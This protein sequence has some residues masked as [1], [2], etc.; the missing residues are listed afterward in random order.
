MEQWTKVIWTD[1]SKFEILGS[2]RKVYVWWKVGES[3]NPLYY[4]NHK[5]RRRLCY[6]LGG[7]SPIAKSEICTRW[8][9]NWIRL[10]ITAYCSIMQSHLE[11]GWWVK[12]FY[13]C[14]IMTQ[15]IRVN[16]TRG[17][18]KAKRNSTSFNS[19]INRLKSHRP[20]VG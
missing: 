2:N 1:E 7:R 5:A 14:K 20:V 19:T 10:A 6:G 17:T 3:C 9:E 13:S 18:S 16:S 4:T 12:D 8:M 11:H 15:S